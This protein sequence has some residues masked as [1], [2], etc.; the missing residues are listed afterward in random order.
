MLSHDISVPSRWRPDLA[1]TAPRDAAAAGQSL[2]TDAVLSDRIQTMRGLAVL[3][4]VSFHAIYT[5]VDTALT[6]TGLRSMVFVTHLFDYIRMPLFGFVAGFV[7]A[8]KP[9]S[10]ETCRQFAA[11]KVTRLLVPCVVATTSMFFLE[12]LAGRLPAGLYL[13]E[14][15]RIY[16]Y[17]TWQFWFIQALLVDFVVIAALEAVG[18]LDTLA[19]LVFVFAAAIVALVWLPAPPTTLFSVPQAEYLLP[20]FLLGLA[21]R[22]FR[23]QLLTSTVASASLAVFFAALAIHS[24]Y[25]AWDPA[26]R[27]DRG[28]LLS[29]I[30]GCSAG[31]CA[32]SWMPR[33]ALLR[34]LG[35]YSFAIYLYHYLFINVA[36]TLC[37]RA[38]FR[39]ALPLAVVLI[40]VGI[41]GP[42]IVYSAVRR[43]RI[44]RSA[45]LGMR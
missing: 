30:V 19:R 13:H 44:L 10:R 28:S 23:A 15:W 32:V 27:L 12:L 8:L 22:R 6:T 21:M 24:T 38:D 11:R 42:L 3:M 4:L 39:S 29:V 33:I 43:N 25:V 31:L 18:A 45:M 5:D 35:G 2:R 37:K 9:I 36:A 17:P 1:R 34:L 20:F 16:L 40:G 41:V 7:Y 14:A 26:Y